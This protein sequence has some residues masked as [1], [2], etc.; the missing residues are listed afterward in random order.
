MKIVATKDIV[1]KGKRTLVGSFERRNGKNKKSISNESQ[2]Q[3]LNPIVLK[4]VTF[5]RI[6]QE[7]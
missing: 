7:L 2:A 5:L 4:K 1:K 6:D 3:T